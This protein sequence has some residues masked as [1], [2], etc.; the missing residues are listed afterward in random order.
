[1]LSHQKMKNDLDKQKYTRMY[2][3]N[4]YLFRCVCDV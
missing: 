2:V 1:M 4:V 3:L